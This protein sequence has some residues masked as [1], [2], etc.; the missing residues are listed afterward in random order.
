MALVEQTTTDH[1]IIKESKYSESLSICP[2]QI[3]RLTNYMHALAHASNIC[4]VFDSHFW[5]TI[6][7][8]SYTINGPN[9]FTYTRSPVVHS[10]HFRWILCVHSWN[11]HIFVW[12]VGV[13][14]LPWLWFCQ[15][16]SLLKHDFNY[17][18]HETQISLTF[19]TYL[20]KMHCFRE[21]ILTKLV[22]LTI[23][24]CI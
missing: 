17:T 18:D 20:S 21:S 24:L 2:S 10:G 4:I 1:H 7:C 13:L 23:T 19:S 11:V 6:K 16:I 3:H 12:I 14:I 8:C 15:H 9:M 5:Y 22:S